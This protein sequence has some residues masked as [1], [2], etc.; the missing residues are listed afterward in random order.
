M[1]KKD[2]KKEV[3]SKASLPVKTAIKAG[4][5]LNSKIANAANKSN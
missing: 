5:S 1:E 4:L 2:S 3:V